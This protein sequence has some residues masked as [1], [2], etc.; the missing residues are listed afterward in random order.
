MALDVKLEIRAS[1]RKHPRYNPAIGGEASIKGNCG[2]CTA[3]FAL[4]RQAQTVE[5]MAEV[6]E[7]GDAVRVAV[8]RWKKPA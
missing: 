5:G 2:A 7:A 4:Y 8:L 6:L 1:C 3:L